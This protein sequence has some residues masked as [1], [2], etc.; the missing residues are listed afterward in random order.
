MSPTDST[1]KPVYSFDDHNI[2]LYD[3]TKGILTTRTLKRP[4][5][6]K[7]LSDWWE[8]AGQITALIN[9]VAVESTAACKPAL[10][11]LYRPM[12]SLKSSDGY[13][14]TSAGFGFFE[15]FNLAE[16][17][18]KAL[19]GNYHVQSSEHNAIADGNG[20]YYLLLSPEP[21]ALAKSEQHKDEAIKAAL[22]KL[23]PY[24]IELLGLKLA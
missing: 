7:S 10:I 3:T 22:S 18:G 20:G 13:T 5:W 6:C 24:E 23:T 17:V 21:V 15:D 9:K 16:T 14:H 1:F 11:K 12:T 8:F 2:G 19:S 4:I